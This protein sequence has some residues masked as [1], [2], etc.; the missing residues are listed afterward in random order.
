MSIKIKKKQVALSAMLLALG[1]AVFINWYYTKPQV[2]SASDEITTGASQ[3]NENLGDAEYVA[4]TAAQKSK[5]DFAKFSVERKSAHDSAEESLNKV[6]KDQS[7]S[8]AAIAK[9][10]EAL[11]ELSRDIKREADLETLIKAK[12]GGEC[13]VIIDSGSVKVVVEQGKLT[14][15]VTMQIKE[16]VL[17]QGKFSPENITIFELNG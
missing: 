7:S 8:Q 5:D 13:I 4:A 12:T 11:E 2:K 10:S 16:L 9:A 1:A 3:Q 17:N 6:I 14:D 15:N